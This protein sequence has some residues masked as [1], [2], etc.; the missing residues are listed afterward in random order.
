MKNMNRAVRR[1]HFDRMKQ[2]AVKIELTR[3]YGY[4]PRWNS[5]FEGNGKHYNGTLESH[6][7]F[8]KDISGYQANNLAKCSCEMCG[9]PRKYFQKVE[10]RLTIQELK[11]LEREANEIKE[12]FDKG[13]LT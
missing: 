7:E 6:R 10:D 1:H 9:N 4:N 11:C 13:D 12:W 8:A 5:G 2:K 3:W